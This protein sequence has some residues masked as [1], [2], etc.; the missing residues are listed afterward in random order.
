MLLTAVLTQQAVDGRDISGL[1]FKGLPTFETFIEGQQTLDI[2]FG[3][4]GTSTDTVDNDAHGVE[5]LLRCEVV[6]QVVGAA[7]EE[8]GLRT[9]G[10]DLMETTDDAMGIVADNTT[11]HNTSSA[12]KD[13]PVATILREAVAK[14]D[15]RCAV[16]IVELGEE[17][18]TLKVV[19]CLCGG[20]TGGKK[21]KE[22]SEEDATARDKMFH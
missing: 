18:Y 11:V 21:G 13:V 20:W 1:A 2:E 14:H 15:N 10:K 3:A 6:A 7:H 4:R 5:Y 8:D 12:Q 16:D 17:V 22:E 9:V 19:C